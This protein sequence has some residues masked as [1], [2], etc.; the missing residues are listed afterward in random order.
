VR[1]RSQAETPKLVAALERID[2]NTEDSL[3]IFRNNKA[4][5]EGK[6]DEWAKAFDIDRGLWHLRAP[7][8]LTLAKIGSHVQIGP[9][10]ESNKKLSSKDADRY[11][12]AIRTLESHSNIS[13][14]IVSCRSSLLSILAGHALYS[15]RV[16]VLVPDGCSANPS[17]IKKRIKKDFVHM[18]WK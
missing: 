1:I 13:T 6:L 12:Q 18:G 10:V 5:T 16:Y 3:E 4:L 2:S 8:Q 11:E 15:L 17:D 7:K 9:I 14:P